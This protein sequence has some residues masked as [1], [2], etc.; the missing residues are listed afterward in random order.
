MYVPASLILLNLLIHCPSEYQF[1]AGK[2]GRIVRM[3]LSER[4][5]NRFRPTAGRDVLFQPI[6]TIS[7]SALLSK[8]S[9]ELV[10]FLGAM[11][12]DGDMLM[13]DSSSLLWATDYCFSPLYV[14][15]PYFSPLGH[16]ELI[17]LIGS[18]SMTSKERK[19]YAD[20]VLAAWTNDDVAE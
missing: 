4:N 19:H 3:L 11:K 15:Q 9:A 14:R 20:R 13:F 10:G 6:Q 16:A 17:S 18:Y 5:L 2:D 7:D 8:R 12:S 1:D